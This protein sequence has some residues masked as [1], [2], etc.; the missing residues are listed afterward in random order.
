M[1]LLGL[2]TFIW[3]TVHHDRLSAMAWHW[4]WILAAFSAICAILSIPIFL[5]VSSTWSFV[6]GFAGVLAQAIV[7][8]QVIN[9]I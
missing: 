1:Q 5:V 3:P 9:S 2:L 8:L 7:Q 4:I 6:I